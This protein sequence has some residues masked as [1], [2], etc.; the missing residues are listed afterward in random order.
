LIW[1]G[2][3]IVLLTIIAIVKRYETRMVML[4]SG[5]ALAAIAGKP[6]A[7]MDALVKNMV[8]GVLFPN[9]L[10][11]MGFAYVMKLTECD[12]HLVHLL[13]DKLKKFRGLLIPG[14]VFI[15]YAINVALPS[16]AG[17][18]AAVGTIMIPV[19]MGSGVHP[20]IAGSAVLAGTFGSTISPGSPQNIFM[21]KVANTNIM[22]TVYTALPGSLTA[23]VIVALTLT[24][25]AYFRKEHKG[26][27]SDIIGD[28]SHEFKVSIP[29]ALMPLVPLALLVAFTRHG[30]TIPMAVLVGT[31]VTLLVTR[32]NPQSLTK[33]FFA[34]MGEAYAHICGI[35]L[36][37]AV[38]VVGMDTIG[39]I[40]AMIE[41]MKA[42]EH[43]AK[44][45][46]T[47]GPFI[48][49]VLSGSGDAAALAFNGAVT[50]HAQ[51]FGV[52]VLDMGITAAITA[53]IGRAMSPVAGCTI[54]CAQL[55]GVSPLDLTKRNALGTILAATAVMLILL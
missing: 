13:A 54:I 24:A 36:A 1:I 44:V 45:A 47:Y 28:P 26:Y 48:V 17:V 35:I 20:A 2:A 16:A 7:A 50:P 3:L 31:V 27:E 49:A 14:A 9:I 25:I 29:K 46:A 10:M 8:N 53:G 4:V 39:L 40:R 33:Q 51:Q 23:V 15:T 41:T 37:A 55:A 22:S 5:F 30:V 43:I 6:F 19:L 32:V 42:S 38:F 11:I 12:S 34:G 21:M 52:G 18:A